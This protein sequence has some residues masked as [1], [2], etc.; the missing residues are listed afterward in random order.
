MTGTPV[1][2]KITGS[3]PKFQHERDGYVCLNQLSK[4]ELLDVL[5]R[6]KKILDNK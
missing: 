5:Q 1:I 6:E 4:T 2:K 3:L